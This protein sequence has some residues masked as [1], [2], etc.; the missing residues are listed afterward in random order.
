[1]SATV[2]LT[3]TTTTSPHSLRLFSTPDHQLS[4]PSSERGGGTSSTSS[5][6]SSSAESWPMAVE[7]LAQRLWECGR[8]ALLSRRS[9]SHST[10]KDDEPKLV[11]GGEAQ[12]GGDHDDDSTDA[13][14]D[15]GGLCDGPYV[16]VDYSGDVAQ[17]PPVPPTSL[18]SLSPHHPPPVSATVNIKEGEQVPALQQHVACGRPPLIRYQPRTNPFKT[19][20]RMPLPSPT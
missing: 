1:M 15:I 10:S 19:M 2:T 7:A 11:I 5:S 9:S 20:M 6:S 16:R 13:Q 12:S 18:P 14:D 17:F 4:T 8:E 3:T